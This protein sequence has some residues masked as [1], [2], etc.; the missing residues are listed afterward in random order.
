MITAIDNKQTKSQTQLKVQDSLNMLNKLMNSNGVAS[1]VFSK[2]KMLSLANLARQVEKNEASKQRRVEERNGEASKY[3]IDTVLA[4]YLQNYRAQ[5]KALLLL[6]TQELVSQIKG[7]GR[8]LNDKVV[9]DF[10]RAADGILGELFVSSLATSAFYPNNGWGE[11]STPKVIVGVDRDV[12][13]ILPL[14]QEVGLLKNSGE[15]INR[16]KYEA[17]RGPIDSLQSSSFEGFPH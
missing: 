14:A 6:N 2:D 15:L 11:V 8:P 13:Q 17:L 4:G 3:P 16:T 9:D 5:A 1:V 12:L 10:V 7:C